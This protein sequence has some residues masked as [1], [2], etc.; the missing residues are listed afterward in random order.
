MKHH[1]LFPTLCL[2][3][4]CLIIQVPSISIATIISSNEGCIEIQLKCQLDQSL[5]FSEM[6]YSGQFVPDKIA[7]LLLVKKNRE[8]IHN[9]D[10]P[11]SR[12]P[13]R[14]GVFGGGCPE[15]PP[16]RKDREQKSDSNE[17]IDK[18]SD[19]KAA[20]K[21]KGDMKKGSH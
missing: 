2:I 12:G 6:R 16:C 5:D 19:E 10:F 7:R 18:K 4:V 15:G 17:I 3:L 21:K 9:R 8:D 20:D 11:R 1:F 14:S 13:R